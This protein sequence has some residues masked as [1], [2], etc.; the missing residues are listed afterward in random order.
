MKC[1]F[2][3]DYR[4]IFYMIPIDELKAFNSCQDEIDLEDFDKYIVDRL[5]D[6]IITK[7]EKNNEN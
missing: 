6:I 2:Q 5:E 7:W 4:G 1:V 3:M